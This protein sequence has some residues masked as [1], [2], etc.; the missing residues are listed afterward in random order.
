MV[1]VEDFET[2]AFHKDACSLVEGAEADMTV[3]RHVYIYIQILCAHMEVNIYVY[4]CQNK[5]AH[6]RKHFNT[7]LHA[8]RSVC[9]RM[10]VIELWGSNWILTRP[11]GCKLA[12]TGPL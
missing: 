12:R 9:A 1:W 4:T 6:A 11:C 3:D 10:D 5:H 8:K 2:Q 7:N